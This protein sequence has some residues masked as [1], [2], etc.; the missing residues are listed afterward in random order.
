VNSLAHENMKY[1]EDEMTN[2]DPNIAQRQADFI[3]ELE[4][5]LAELK[6]APVPELSS[7]SAVSEQEP[8]VRMTFDLSK[9]QHRRFRTLCSSLDR[10]M[11]D[12]FR[13]FV[14]RFIEENG[15]K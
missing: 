13:A 14:A 15:A 8:M 9:E 3:E 6:A 10:N 12:E 11:T 1:K 2:I 7:A 5:K 4:E